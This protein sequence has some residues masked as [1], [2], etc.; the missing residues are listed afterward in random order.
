[1]RAMIWHRLRSRVVKQTHPDRRGP[2]RNRETPPYGEAI[3]RRS[4]SPQ[5][6]QAARRWNEIHIQHLRKRVTGFKRQSGAGALSERDSPSVVA[7]VAQIHPGLSGADKAVRTRRACR[8]V[9]DSLGHNVPLRSREG[10]PRETS[11]GICTPH[12]SNGI[13]VHVLMA[14]AG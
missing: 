8:D 3:A 10:T 7:A 13:A 11:R 2:R 5:Y 1:M 14:G 6:R 4:R 12:R 9:V